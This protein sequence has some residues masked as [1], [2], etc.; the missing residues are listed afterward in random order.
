MYLKMLEEGKFD[1]ILTFAAG[2]HDT[3]Y[4]QL[5][6]KRIDNANDDNESIYKKF[7][8]KI[9]QQK[10]REI[11]SDCSVNL[12]R[13]H[14][15]DTIEKLT[16]LFYK[17]YNVPLITLQLNCCKMPK[18]SDIAMIWRKNLYKMKN[19]FNLLETG[20]RGYVKNSNGIPLRDAIVKINNIFLP[21]TKNLA[22]FR[23]ILPPGEI[24][25]EILSKG[26]V[27]HKQLILIMENK[28][29]NVG[30]IILNEITTTT[31]TNDK[32]ITDKWI[33]ETDNYNKTNNN[34][35]SNTLEYNKN[36]HFREIS[37]F[38]LSEFNN[39]LINA[40]VSIINSNFEIYN[41]TDSFGVFTFSN[42]PIGDV[43]LI[44]EATGYFKSDR[45][46]F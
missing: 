39:P 40:K 10:L 6:H 14:H 32:T 30:V 7:V 25:I 13:S 44:A 46:I 22:H 26:Y 18:N 23:T 33:N 36:K 35:S 15:L 24:E 21:V 8:Q 16:N 28:I 37:G 19:F 27:T 45:Y 9:N 43:G 11:N 17:I 42:A 29:L 34:N 1:L 31:T 4:P 2:G 12:E 20:I 41:R 38:V 5:E 3:I